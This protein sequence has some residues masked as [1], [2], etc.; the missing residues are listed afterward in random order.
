M[1]SGKASTVLQMT[2]AIRGP[3]PRPKSSTIL[4]GG[5]DG[6]LYTIDYDGRN[7]LKLPTAAGRAGTAVWA[8]DGKLILYL[9]F[10]PGPGALTTLRELSQETGEDKLI[11]KTSQF[12][13]FGPNGNGSVFVGASAN[14]AGPHIL[15]LVRLGGRE[16]TLCEHRAADPW[17][18]KPVFSPDSRI[19]FFESDRDGKPAIYS[20]PVTNLVERT[21]S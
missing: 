13:G 7:N 8:S 10:P 12:V 1:G 3:A 20:M 16:L 17:N 6:A 2:G 11:A 9:N 21:E 14:K 4:Y 5:P 19:I 15:L 18:V